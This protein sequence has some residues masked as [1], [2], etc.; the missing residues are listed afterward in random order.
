MRFTTYLTAA[1]LLLTLGGCSALT[2]VGNA[3]QNPVV[4]GTVNVAS[5]KECTQ[6]AK[7]QPAAAKT[8]EQYLA[9]LAGATQA[10]VD[11]INAGLAPAK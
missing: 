11:G 7:D 1:A 3:Q 4:Q 6:F 9:T 8:T 10:C 2:Q 5:Q